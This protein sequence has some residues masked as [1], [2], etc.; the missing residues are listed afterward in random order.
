[1]WLRVPCC[2]A[3]SLEALRA[4]AFAGLS[5]IVYAL[6]SA[7]G[8]VLAFV[9]GAVLWKEPLSG[10]NRLGVALAVVAV[11]LLNLD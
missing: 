2:G 11:V 1:M 5:A 8:V 7:A 4:P 3:Y 10:R 6:Y 9:A